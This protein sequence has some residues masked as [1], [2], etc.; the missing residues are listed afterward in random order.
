[1]DHSS[2]NVTSTGIREPCFVLDPDNPGMPPHPVPLVRTSTARRSPRG[3]DPGVALL[4]LFPGGYLGAYVR[5]A[6]TTLL[7]QGR[8]TFQQSAQQPLSRRRGHPDPVAPHPHLR[9]RT[10]HVVLRSRP[11]AGIAGSSSFLG[12]RSRARRPLIEWMHDPFDQPRP[13]PAPLFDRLDRRSA[14]GSTRD[15]TRSPTATADARFIRSPGTMARPPR[16]RTTCSRSSSSA[17]G[18]RPRRGHRRAGAGGGGDQPLRTRSRDDGRRP[19]PG[20]QRTSALDG[21]DARVPRDD[22]R[23]VVPVVP[24]RGQPRRLLALTPASRG[25][26]RGSVRG[27]LRRSGTP[28]TTR[29]AGS[30]SSTPTS[31]TRRPASGTS[32]SRSASG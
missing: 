32:A 25:G 28:S 9:N 31:R 18:R 2:S 5:I 11:P 30:S 26:T 27:A 24:R 19:H 14:G 23:A 21:R 8:Q 29:T 4:R 22:G 12:V 13:C 10:Q 3:P 7:N 20:L 16:R 15:R 17:T 6:G 1:M